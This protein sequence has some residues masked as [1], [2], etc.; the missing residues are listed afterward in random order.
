M[1]SIITFP[2]VCIIILTSFVP[3]DVNDKVLAYINSYQSLAISEMERTGIP[4]SIK[5]AQ[6]LLESG[7]G[8]STLALE[9]N[10][11]FGIKCGS[12]WQGKEYYVY[13]DDYKNGKK[14]KSCFR[15]FNS[16]H[17]SY[18]AHSE[19]LSNPNKER[20]ALLFYF[21]PS[22][23]KAW[24][25]GLKDAGYAT[26]PKYPSKLISLIEKY[27]LHKFDGEH[28]ILAY[29]EYDTPIAY[30][31][32]ESSNNNRDNKST[33][34]GTPKSSHKTVM[35]TEER[36]AQPSSPH[37][38]DEKASKESRRKKS[39]KSSL[40]RLFNKDAKQSS[41]SLKNADYHIVQTGET[42]KQLAKRYGMPTA[43]LYSKNRMPLGTQPIAGEK[44][45]LKGT[46]RIGDR[47]QFDY[48]ERT[49]SVSEFVFGK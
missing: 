3:R 17:E 7:W 19:F 9:A 31:L 43:L 20:Y 21:P 11:H 49:H 29:Q 8:Q 30:D 28:E 5:L 18:I 42:M 27:E 46:V 39:S 35:I 44:L 34:P 41:N 25:Y 14:I 16:A 2:I 22:D 1:K 40:S 37:H 6:G 33:K 36:G 10:N 4:A 23:Y 48:P 38:Y 32:G 26:D 24:A 45:Q 47:P 12:H 15:A 13:D